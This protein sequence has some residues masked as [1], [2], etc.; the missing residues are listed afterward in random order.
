MQQTTTVDTSSKQ[1]DISP[2]IQTPHESSQKNHVVSQGETHQEA[3][4]S[5]D[6]MFKSPSP[7]VAS[8]FTPQ[9]SP[10]HDI[11]PTMQPL[12]EAIDKTPNNPSSSQSPITESVLPQVTGFE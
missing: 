5:P 3:Y 8:L 1:M 2:P 6:H 9:P 7:R 12:F 4:E 10:S 11:Q